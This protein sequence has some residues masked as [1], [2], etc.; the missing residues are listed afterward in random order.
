[1]TLLLKKYNLILI[2]ISC[3]MLCLLASCSSSLDQDTIKYRS[4]QTPSNQQY[5][6]QQTSPYY[7]QQQQQPMV[8]PGYTGGYGYPPA[9]R[10]YS[11]PYAFPPANQ[12]PYYDSDKYY[13][14]PSNYGTGDSDGTKFEKF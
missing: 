9:S 11:N 5:Y 10:Y 1:M 8:S 12:Y 13:V 2:T 7:Y 6:Q 14:P 3:L 4:N